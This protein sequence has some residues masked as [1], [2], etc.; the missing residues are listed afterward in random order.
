MTK[1]L[2]KNFRHNNKWHKHE[3]DTKT[4]NIKLF[5]IDTENGGD[6]VELLTYTAQ[7]CI[8]NADRKR[9]GTIS[10]TADGTWQFKSELYGNYKSKLKNLPEA[11][12]EYSMIALEKMSAQPSAVLEN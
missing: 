2:I 5:R 6:D 7:L 11:E 9:I 1:C 10:T 3:I 4:D 12:V 8:L